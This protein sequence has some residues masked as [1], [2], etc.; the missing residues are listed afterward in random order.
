MVDCMK[1]TDQFCKEC[2]T[3]RHCFESDERPSRL[4]RRE[5]PIYIVVDD[6]GNDITD[7]LFPE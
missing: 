2:G 1:H 3:Y 6:A 5:M 7:Q 4:V